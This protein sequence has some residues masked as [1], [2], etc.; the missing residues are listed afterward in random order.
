MQRFRDNRLGNDGKQA[1]NRATYLAYEVRLVAVC[2]H[3]N[4]RQRKHSLNFSGSVLWHHVLGLLA[5]GIGWSEPL[6][7][8]AYFCSKQ[9]LGERLW[10]T[11]TAPH[12]PTIAKKPKTNYNQPVQDKKTSYL[13]DLM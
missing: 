9:S 12:I 10:I 8:R 3:P 1:F 7:G 11:A 13:N 2:L 4:S 5:A 6:A